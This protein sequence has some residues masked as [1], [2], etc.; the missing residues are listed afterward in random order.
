MA[1]NQIAPVRG[2]LLCKKVEQE[3]SNGILRPTS[4][5]EDKVVQTF[6]ILAG[7][8]LDHGE[9][10]NRVPVTWVFQNGALIYVP[11]SKALS[12]EGQDDLYFVSCD[13]VLGTFRPAEEASKEEG[14]K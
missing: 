4:V 6:E 2:K 10:G 13:D 12:I 1:S 14:D 8:L 7:E 9:I 3:A 5:S 11:R